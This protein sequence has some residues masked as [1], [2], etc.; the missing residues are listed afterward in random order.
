MDQTKWRKFSAASI[1]EPQQIRDNVSQPLKQ[2][3]STQAIW[4]PLPTTGC[5]IRCSGT[6]IYYNFCQRGYWSMTVIASW[7]NTEA[8]S[9]LD[10]SATTSR[11][12]PVPVKYIKV[13]LQIN[14]QYDAW[15]KE[16]ICLRLLA[17]QAN[18][19]RSLVTSAKCLLVLEEQGTTLNMSSQRMLS[20]DSMQWLTRMVRL[21]LSMNQLILL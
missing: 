2:L 12:D 3:K 14:F 16:L 8:H 20:P 19:V 1:T 18:M 13:Q 21:F 10:S 9:A 15:E 11:F 6:C 4:F 5:P 7:S 17:T